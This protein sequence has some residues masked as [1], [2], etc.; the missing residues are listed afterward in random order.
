VKAP[1]AP[2]LRSPL[3]ERLRCD[4]REAHIAAETAFDLAARLN[5]V[6]DYAD[7]L[8][9][10]RAF[11]RACAPALAAAADQLPPALREGPSRRR[12]RLCADL[13]L[14]GRTSAAP[15]FALAP[16]RLATPGP[17]GGL[18][19]WY[20]LE[21]AALGGLRIAAEVR[22]RLPAAV[23]AS[24]FFAGEGRATAGR[25]RAF[26]RV[27]ADW[28]QRGPVAADHVVLGALTAFDALAAGL[29]GIR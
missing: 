12:A 8:S 2:H 25:W 10:T 6:A 21:G 20:V 7:G 24:T 22:R 19:V 26:Q 9:V 14:L 29:E 28:E 13:M 23:P 11:H 4:T 27:L 15:G 1:S 18:G 5:S 16:L 17:D 3:G